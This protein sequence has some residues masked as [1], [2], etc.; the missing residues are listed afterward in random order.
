MNGQQAV[1]RIPDVSPEIK[2]I[3]VKPEVI[4]AGDHPAALIMAD[5][6]AKMG[7]SV[8]LVVP[9]EELSEM[10]VPFFKA[11]IEVDESVAVV[12]GSLIERVSGNPGV[13]ILKHSRLLDVSGWWG[14]FTVKVLTGDKE[15]E[16]K[17]SGI[18]MAYRGNPVA[19]E[20]PVHEGVVDFSEFLSQLDIHKG[21]VGGAKDPVSK[22]AFLL[23]VDK[24]DEKWASVSA[25]KLG[26]YLKRNFGTQ[27]YILC[28]D[29]KVSVD[30]MEREYRHAREL[31]IIIFKYNDLPVIERA[32][33]GIRMIFED[34]SAVS[35][36]NPLKITLD[37]LDTVVIQE[38]FDVSQDQR[39]LLNQMRISLENGFIG[40]N[41]PQ[42]IG[43]TP[44]KG[45]VVGGDTWFPEYPTD[46][47]VT[48]LSAAEELYKWVG[49]GTYQI[50][51]QRV[52]EVDSS[53]CATCLTCYRIC[54]H[55]SIRIERYGERNVYITE[56]EK[57]GATWEAARVKVETCN[58]CGLCVSECPAK[59]IQ[60][61]YYP[62][63]EVMEF[64]EKN[65]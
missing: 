4:A 55:D 14:D 40:P 61:V 41:N 11:L 38:C 34:T 48:A 24:R 49:K 56:G 36:Q 47:V 19:P 8:T 46:G 17:S 51:V 21:T 52:A 20:A 10:M 33:H 53:K 45:V 54:P 31:G 64:L 59:A 16:L 43:R 23:D 58:G 60:L 12:Y 1:L 50:D 15:S 6:L 5:Y 57:E 39:H 65:L 22:I 25:I 35:H 63:M 18:A 30:E 9:F 44:K 7:I 27:V 32:Q 13:K 26:L 62:D 2:E 28:R 37:N 3:S 42:F 29:L